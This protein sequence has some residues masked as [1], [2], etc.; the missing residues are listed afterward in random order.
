MI[1]IFIDESGDLGFSKRSSDIFVI[2]LLMTTK[3]ELIR[4][5]VRKVRDTI[6]KKNKAPDELHWNSSNEVI[7]KRTLKRL[8]E[9]DLEL[10]LLILNKRKVYS[11]LQN[12]KDKLYH[13][14][15]G[16]ILDHACFDD[17]KVKIIFD[18]R[19]KDRFVRADL[20]NYI[21]KKV[22]NSNKD[23]LVEVLHKRSVDDR[24]LQAVDMIAGATFT[25]Y[26]H[27]N[28][29]FLDIIKHLITTEKKLFEKK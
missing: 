23:V 27:N 9:L 5:T 3:P 29:E 18:K 28:S 13:Y 10:H 20:S 26:Q 15:S 14:L 25:K 4:R 16:L 12:E 24:G 19:S 1:T 21:H 11:Y 7:K 6:K 17:N 8:S 22:I 2:A